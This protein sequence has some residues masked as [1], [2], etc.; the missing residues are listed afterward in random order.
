MA[1]GVYIQFYEYVLMLVC[2]L[3]MLTAKLFV[4]LQIERIFAIQRDAFFCIAWT[5]ITITILYYSTSLFVFAFHC[6]PLSKAWDT[7][8]EAV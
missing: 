4:L 8:L 7:S 2:P 1:V 3:C 5:V 6:T